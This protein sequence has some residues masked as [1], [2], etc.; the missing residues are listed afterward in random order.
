MI[1]P[2]AF[3]IWALLLLVLP[4]WGAAIVAVGLLVASNSCSRESA[5]IMCL[6]LLFMPG[7]IIALVLLA[8]V[9]LFA[10]GGLEEEEV[11][12]ANT[13]AR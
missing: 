11:A 2:V 9:I 6:I 1:V 7:P 4:S 13:G 5:G 8:G 12:T 3:L 10:Y